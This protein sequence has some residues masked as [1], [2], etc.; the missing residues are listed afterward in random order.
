MEHSAYTA[1]IIIKGSDT[2]ILIIMLTNES[3]TKWLQ[4][5]DANR[6]LE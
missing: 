5:L 6:D 2:D 1:N 4:N 3:R